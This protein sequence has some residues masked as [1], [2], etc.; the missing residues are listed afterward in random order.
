MA[1]SLFQRI[2]EAYETLSNKVKRQRY[3]LELQGDKREDR[4]EAKI[5][6]EAENAFQRGVVLLNKNNFAQAHKELEKAVNLYQEEPEY[7]CYL[8]WA[9][10]KSAAG[11]AIM[12][13]QAKELIQKSIRLNPNL[14]KGHLFHGYMLKEAGRL[15]EAEKKFERAIQCN[16]KCTEA[17]RELRLI[18]LRSTSDNDASV[19]GKLFKK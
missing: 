5:I 12:L 8:G 7:L 6:I 11:D 16:Q 2:G 3:L 17:L 19:L 10:F 4:D 1:N 9:K 18:N 15:P 14:D 13:E